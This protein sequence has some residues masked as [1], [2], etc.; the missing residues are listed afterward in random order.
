MGIFYIVVFVAF[1][2]FEDSL[3]Q[4]SSDKDELLNWC[5]KGINHK[6]KPG[7]EDRLHEQ[8][9][10]WK[11][12]ACCTESVSYDVHQVNMYN[13]T[14][15]HCYSQLK[16]NMS[17]QCRK[18]FDRDNCFYECEPH[19]GLWVVTTTRKIASERF[20][21]VPLCASDCNSWFEACKDDYTC[22]YNWPRDF[23][24]TK[25]Q[26]M[27]RE[28]SK[29]VTFKD[30]YHTP[31]D[32]CENVWD[33]S[34]K[35]VDDSVPC[36]HMWFNG[37]VTETNRKTAEFYIDQQFGESSTYTFQISYKFITAFLVI[38]SCLK[39]YIFYTC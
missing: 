19:I 4:L 1:S 5:L 11:D 6:S 2:L 36:M 16:R 34:W 8:C 12:H 21:K 14:F 31:K 3:C 39:N 22:A 23:K 28:D 17:A 35:Y 18:Y 32:F 10:P 27:C 30:M 20:Y 29:C 9:E 7:K 26:N 25:G 13:F 15:D 38:T 37:T 24:F 33:H